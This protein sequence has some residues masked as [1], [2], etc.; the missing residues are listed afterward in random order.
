MK[1]S[2]SHSEL[3]KTTWD[4]AEGCQGTLSR[5]G[6]PAN[7]AWG[8]VPGAGTQWAV[9]PGP[10]TAVLGH[11]LGFLF[12]ES[13]SSP[14]NQPPSVVTLTDSSLRISAERGEAGPHGLAETLSR[15]ARASVLSRQEPWSARW[16]GGTGCPVSTRR[17]SR[18][19]SEISRSRRSPRFPGILREKVR[20][21]REERGVSQRLKRLRWVRW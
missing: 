20:F 19:A 5:G 11:R 10:C 15:K 3:L 13:V 14:R 12:P 8:W 6:W 7:Q 4:L 21:L 18:V 16:A 2:E 17:P 9:S 1:A